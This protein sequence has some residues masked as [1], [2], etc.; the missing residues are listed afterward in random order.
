MRGRQVHFFD[1]A[2]NFR[3]EDDYGWLAQQLTITGLP[4]PALMAHDWRLREWQIAN[5]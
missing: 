4:Q 1:Y 5:H 3:T 2:R